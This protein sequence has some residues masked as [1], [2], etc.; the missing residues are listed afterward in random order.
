M[1]PMDQRTLEESIK[2]FNADFML[3]TGQTECFPTT[4]VF[5]SEWQLKKHGNYWGESTL[6]VD[7]AVMDDEGNFL[8]PETEGEIVWRGPGVMKMYLKNDK[9]TNISRKYAWHHSG[10]LGYF[11]KDG[12]LVFVDRK[13]DIIKSGGENVASIK[14]ERIILDHPEVKAVAVIGLPHDK[15]IE[16][17]T[18]FVVP[19]KNSNLTENDILLL[20]KEHLGNFEIPKKVVFLDELPKTTTGKLEKYKIRTQFG[21]LYK[22]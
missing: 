13:K 20:C 12:L 17:I 18:A 10:D 1:T 15:W 21:E 2:T 7:T 4:N 19:V 8:P 22:S 5:H 16:A 14:V 9:D 6:A 3:V 11:D